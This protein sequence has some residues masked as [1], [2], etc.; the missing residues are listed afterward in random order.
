MIHAFH[1]ALRGK[2]CL[3]VS[4]LTFCFLCASP[5]TTYAQTSDPDTK[6]W[7]EAEVAPP[8]RFR[9]DRLQMFEVKRDSALA[10]GIDP[11]TLSVGDD[12]V[13]RYVLVA[14]SSSGALN[15]LYQGIRCET[16]EVKTYGRWDNRDSWNTDSKDEWQ[17]LSFSGFTRPAMMLARAGICE[18]RTV[19]GDT[20]KILRILKN[21]RPNSTP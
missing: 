12:G 17:T 20:R 19:S 2:A 1:Q 10:Y 21:G 6:L 3:A 11:E 5:V 8:A 15:A 16:A 7:Q 14:R 9:I 4:A 18:G 13:V